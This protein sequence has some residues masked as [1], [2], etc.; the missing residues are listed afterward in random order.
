[1]TLWNKS[2][3]SEDSFSAR[4]IPRR[5]PAGTRNIWASHYFG[6]DAT[7]TWMINFRVRSLDAMVAQLRAAGIT[8]EI[9]PQEYPNG[10]FA[11]LYDPEGTPSSYGSQPTRTRRDFLP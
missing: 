4:A 3:V 1:M 8:V 11:R 9:D 10:R 5:S 6:P 2:P 7:K